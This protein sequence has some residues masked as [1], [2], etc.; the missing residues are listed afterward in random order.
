MHDGNDAN[1]A[2]GKM[3]VTYRWNWMAWVPGL[4]GLLLAVA[5]HAAWSHAADAVALPPGSVVIAPRA[6]AR[7]GQTEIVTV[8]S[9]QIFAAFLSRFADDAPII[10]AKV[11][12]STDL[13]SADLTETD[14][15]VYSTTELLMSSGRNDVSLKFTVNGVT[16]TKTVALMMP[17]EAPA[18][19]APAPAI[20]TATPLTIAGA[21]LAVYALLTAAFLVARRRSPRAI[22]IRG[23]AQVRGA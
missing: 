21:I 7:S 4:V 22:A 3:R 20:T 9:K 16:S 18:Q 5:P 23:R 12:A 6:E 14:P 1:G 13:Q 8:F 2:A 10:G 17:V 15:G 19:A 11:E